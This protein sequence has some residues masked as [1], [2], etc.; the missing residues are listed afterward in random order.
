[1]QTSNDHVRGATV[2]PLDL[3][4]HRIEF[5]PPADDELDQDEAFFYLAN[6]HGRTRVRFHDYEAIYRTQ[7]LYEQLFYDRLKCKSPRKVA[8]VLGQAV[9]Q[10]HGQPSELRVLDLGAGNGMAGEALA[11]FGVSR[12]VGVDIID[13]ARK[14]TLR[15]R[16]GLYDHYY[17][18]DFSDLDDGPYAELQTWSF[19]CLISVAALGFGDIPPAAVAT[20]MSL[21]EPDGWLA[22]NIKET[23][24]DASDTSGFSAMVRELIFSEY[25][26][27]YH[28][29]RYQHRLSI[30]GKPLS[31]F[32]IVGR[33]CR[34]EF[35]ESVRE[36][37]AA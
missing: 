16:P 2:R 21:V 17:V 12:L 9:L 26:D 1:M 22:F 8:D 24:L 11:S 20:A 15:D 3:P 4:R 6:G 36:I 19:N 18:E 33:K 14:A 31:Y 30:H 37:L 23:F 32:A 28:L 27:L 35:P 25:M 7:G 34:D 29:E 10:S 13:E 5:P